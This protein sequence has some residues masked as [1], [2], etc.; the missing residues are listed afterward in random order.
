MYMEV[1]YGIL[2]GLNWLQY[3]QMVLN[4]QWTYI[5]LYIHSGMASI[6]LFYA[7]SYWSCKGDKIYLLIVVSTIADCWKVIVW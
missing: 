6:K 3:I 2:F 1:P 7:G 5:Y 4:E